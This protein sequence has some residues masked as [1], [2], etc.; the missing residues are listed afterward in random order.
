MRVLAYLHERVIRSSKATS[1]SLCNAA[2]MSRLLDL[3]PRSLGETAVRLEALGF[4]SFLGGGIAGSKPLQRVPAS[5]CLTDRGEHFVR[6][7]EEL[8]NVAVEITVAVVQ[9]SWSVL[10][11]VARSTLLQVSASRRA[12]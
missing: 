3:D 11:E 1:S 4:V 9:R 5:I 12:S 10:Q 7:M 8:P 2:I 6:E